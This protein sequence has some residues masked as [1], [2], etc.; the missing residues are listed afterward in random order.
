[1]KKIAKILLSA[2][3]MSSMALGMTGCNSE[4]KDETTKAAGGE[5]TTTEAAKTSEEAEKTEGDT[6]AS[7]EEGAM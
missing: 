5:T 1:M 3:V 4:K 2:A 7:S 6:E